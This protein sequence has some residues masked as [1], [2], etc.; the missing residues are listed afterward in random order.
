MN[1]QPPAPQPSNAPGD[2][3]EGSAKPPMR[4]QEQEHFGPLTLQR[5]R[6]DDGRLLI[7][8]REAPGRQG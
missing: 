4:S 6:K 5:M 1:H 2:R 3:G 8:F 7:V